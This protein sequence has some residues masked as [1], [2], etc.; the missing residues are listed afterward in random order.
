MSIATQITALTND[1]N[2]IRNALID[3]SVD[4]STHGFDEFASDIASIVSGSYA[5]LIVNYPSGATC[6]ATNTSGSKA[7]SSTKKLFYVS[8]PSS[9]TDITCVAK[10]EQEQEGATTKTKTQNVTFTTEGQSQEITMSFE[11]VLDL[12]LESWTYSGTWSDTDGK[13]HFRCEDAQSSTTA[14]NRKSGYYTD[15]IDM[16]SYQNAEVIVDEYG[17]SNKAYIGFVLPSDATSGNF[18]MT[19]FFTGYQTI[20]SSGTY[21]I[22]CPSS[23]SYRLQ[24]CGG[25]KSSDGI[26]SSIIVR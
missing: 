7:I 10:I 4:A 25:N 15:S 13:L 26:I 6:T 17:A 9:G 21:N 23:G 14:A 11:I 3:K 5:F 8:A 12:S 19:K 16:G 18:D 24:I 1:R 22:P 20:N 2:A